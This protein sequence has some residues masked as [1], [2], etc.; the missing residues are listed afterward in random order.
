MKLLFNEANCSGCG[1]CKLAC[2]MENFSRVMPSVALLGIE[3]LFPDPGKYRIRF[4]D[5]CGICADTCPADA[6][7][8]ENG[9]F[10]IREDDCILCHECV[11]ACPGHVMII[12]PQNNIPAKC[13]LCGECA[14]TCPREAIRIAD[15]LQE[16]EAR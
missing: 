14:R 9:V 1:I 15:E 16:K 3:G 8:L 10:H 2:S 6:I 12:N 5:Q 4:C 13:I 11:E 7:E